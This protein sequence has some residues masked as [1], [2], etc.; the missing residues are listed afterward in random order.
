MIALRICR[1]PDALATRALNVGSNVDGTC[2]AERDFLR[3]YALSERAE[4]H[5]NKAPDCVRALYVNFV[6]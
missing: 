5:F 4:Q 2:E 6:A 3:W 1:Q